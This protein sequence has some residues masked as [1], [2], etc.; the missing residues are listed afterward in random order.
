M[1]LAASGQ[2]SHAVGVT[3]NV[4]TPDEI[5]IDV[6]DEVIWTNTA[7]SH[8]VNGL[9]SKFPSNPESFG[10]DVGAGWVF[11]HVF[12]IP[13]VYDYQCDPHVAFGMV[14][15]VIVEAAPENT[16]T[17]NFSGMTPHVG[18]T[19]WLSV[20]DN[21]SKVEIARL[22]VTV[23]TSFSID[24]PGIEPGQSYTLEMFAD[25][26]GNGSYDAPPVDHAWRIEIADVI[27]NE[28]LDFVHN[29]NFTDIEWDHRVF[30]NLSGMDPH[31]GQEIYFALIDNESGEIIDRKSETVAVS[32][33][34]ELSNIQAG[35]SYRVDFFSDHNGNGQYDAPSVDHAWRLEIADAMG[36]EV[37]DFVH[38]TNFTDIEWK[39]RLKVRLSG[40]TPHVGQ[41]MTFYVRDW[42]SGEYLD[43]IV[44]DAVPGAD[45]DVESHVI[46]PGSSYWVD[47]YA[48]HNGN[49]IYDA[50]PTDHA[51]RLATGVTMGDVE[52]TFI[53]DTNFTD[54]FESA[55]PTLTINFTGMTPHVGQTGW[56]L[57]LDEDTGE[58]IER[59]SREVEE[60]FSL[61]VQGIVPG[62]SYTVDIFFDHNSNAYYDEPPVDHA[63][64]FALPDVSN[65]EVLDFAHNTNFTDIE[66]EHQLKVLLSG[67]TPHVGQVLTFYVKDQASGPYLDTIVIDAVPGADF[68]VESY[69][70]EPGGSYTVDF[71][72]DHNGNG[73]YDAPPTDHAW[74]LETGET[75]G[76]V[77]LEFIHNT[78]FTDIFGT[79]R[80]EPNTWIDDLSLFPNPAMD[81]LYINAKVYLESVSVFSVT[82]SLVKT[83]TSLQSSNHALSLQGLS[84]GIYFVEVRTKDHGLSVTRLVKR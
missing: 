15:K 2:V 9:Q 10:N 57:I 41:M 39:H 58:I 12:T 64:R 54:I 18:Q 35:K 45:F 25:H 53:H 81:V 38:N 44:I 43:T 72:A 78:D 14:G 28:V 50:P 48:D 5:T 71:Y 59:S 80:V 30:V 22:S 4:F 33:T 37:L 60:A 68:D 32:F 7:G 19:L 62:H 75:N 23:E 26:N 20:K 56:I 24:V 49:G 21:D 40:M 46:E 17:I 8:N 69:V 31:V 79:T 52:L 51:W 83:V 27:S 84:S 34:V 67:M 1:Q 77:E 16:L 74:R 63:W 82:G 66:W 76:D 11:S 3:S 55:A 13:G 42:A 47:F 65:N 70:I 73:I 36:D 29:T 6:G 61:V